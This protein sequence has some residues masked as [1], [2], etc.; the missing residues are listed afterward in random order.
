MADDEG[1]IATQMCSGGLKE[2]LLICAGAM[3]QL[4]SG[5]ALAMNGTSLRREAV[6]AA[7]LRFFNKAVITPC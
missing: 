5:V 4:C 7:A 6:T 1:Q 2:D 3:W